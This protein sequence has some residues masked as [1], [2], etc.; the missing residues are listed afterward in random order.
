[1]A[2]MSSSVTSSFSEEG[3]VVNGGGVDE[4]RGSSW[5]VKCCCTLGVIT[6]LRR[7]VDTEAN[8]LFRPNLFLGRDGADIGDGVPMEF[9]FE[10]VPYEV[11]DWLDD[12]W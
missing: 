6:A 8:L 10:L 1:M 9:E 12:G 7:E 5:D 2:R 11:V 4:R 3:S